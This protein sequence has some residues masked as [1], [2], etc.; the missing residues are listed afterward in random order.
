MLIFDLLLKNEYGNYTILGHEVP[1]V[2]SIASGILLESFINK[3]TNS[4][5]KFK[6]PD[7]IDNE[8]LGVFN[9]FGI[10][11]S[12]YQR[13]IDSSDTNFILVD[14][15]EDPRVDNALMILDHHPENPT[16]KKEDTIFYQNDISSST[17]ALL[18]RGNEK[19]FDREDILVSLLGLY[20]D[21]ASFNST[22]ALSEDKEWALSMIDIFNFNQKEL[23]N[24]GLCITDINNMDIDGIALNGLKKYKYRN[25]LIESSY[26]QIEEITEEKLNNILKYL[27][28]Y[29]EKNNLDYFVF[30]VHDM[31]NMKSTT[32][33]ITKEGV[34]DIVKYEKYTSRGSNIISNLYNK[35]DGLLDHLKKIK[36]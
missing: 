18:V 35:I 32:Y 30:I 10:D 29:L 20:L 3:H 28:N 23:Y 33:E 1:D 14:H 16:T 24:I 4:K 5:A 8:T 12:I 26:I 21:T 36:R 6:I 31:N 34:I 19:Y 17:S 11:I 27:S 2:D 15:S 25:K 13:P 7:N 22:K 9:H